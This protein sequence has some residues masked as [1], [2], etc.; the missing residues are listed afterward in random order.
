MAGPDAE[1][2]DG[3]EEEGVGGFADDGAAD[4]AL[5]E[6][7]AAVQDFHAGHDPGVQEG[8]A[9]EGDEAAEGDARGLPQDGGEGVLHVPAVGGGQG[10]DEREGAG[11]EEVEEDAEPNDAAGLGVAVDFHEDIAEDVGDGEEQVAAVH[12]DEPQAGYLQRFDGGNVGDDPDGAGN[13]RQGWQP[14]AGAGW[15]LRW[16]IRHYS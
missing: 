12:R 13:G 14:A 1:E 16:F 9:G 11:G 7:A 2:G 4:G 15:L 3:G 10:A 5:P 6:V 8:A